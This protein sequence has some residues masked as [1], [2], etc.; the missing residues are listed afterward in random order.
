MIAGHKQ[1]DP[2]YIDT[3]K[4]LISRGIIELDSSILVVCG[5]NQDRE[6]LL[7]IELTNV[8]ISNLDERMTG[9]EFAP[10][11]WS[12]Q[13]AESITY[14]DNS[15]DFTLVHWGLHHCYSPHRALLEMY[16]V[17]RK[18]LIVF[19]PYD[20]FLTRMG[21]RLGFG[22]VYELAAVAGTGLKY[23]G[24][25]TALFLTMYIASANLKLSRQLTHLRHIVNTDSSSNT[26]LECLAQPE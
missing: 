10:Y 25:P 4:K 18:G 17:A 22:Q 5:G 12:Y 14:A 20:G 11:N 19:E 13:D 21:T 6:A 9:N 1:P 2:H 8:I 24:V 16:R 3:M 26:I 7:H 15:F 23:G